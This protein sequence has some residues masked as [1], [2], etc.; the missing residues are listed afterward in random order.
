SNVAADVVL[1]NGLTQAQQDGLD[2]ALAY[3][4]E[5]QQ[6]VF[7]DIVE[8]ERQRSDEERKLPACTVN[9]GLLAGVDVRNLSV[10]SRLYVGSINFELTEEHIQR[11]FSEFGSVSS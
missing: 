10:M 7:K 9:P 5:L 8:E 2:R 1:P 3:A 6:T 4:R 11:V